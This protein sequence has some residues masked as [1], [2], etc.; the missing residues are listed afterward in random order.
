[1]KYLQSAFC[2]FLLT[3]TAAAQTASPTQASP[4]PPKPPTSPQITT[5]GGDAVKGPE[6][7]LTLDQMKVLYVAMG[8]DKT[9]DQ[10]LGSMLAMQKSRASFIPEDVW[11]DLD[12]SFKKIDYVPALLDIY[13]K[14]LSTEDAAKLIDFSKTEA[15]KHFL[16]SLPAT[17]REVAQAVQ[18]EQQTVGQEVQARHKD[19]IQAAVK[20]YQEERQQKA[21]PS[22]SGPT[23]GAPAGS[24]AT[25]PGPSS[26]TS[27][28]TAPASSG[29]GSSTKPATP[30]AST[31]PQN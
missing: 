19:E 23:Q 11:D 31:T 2:G 14:Y 7:P 22:L 5:L 15:G 21:A 25:S 8:Y 27:A 18:K 12:S 9:I 30:P 28:P 10:S 13:K 6:H 26:G 16:E 3:V 24:G 1:M 17:T 4:T 29:A 20:K